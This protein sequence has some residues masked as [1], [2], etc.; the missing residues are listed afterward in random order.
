MLEAYF[1]M[2]KERAA[3]GLPP[4]PLTPREVEE[5]CRALET[6]AKDEGAALRGLLEDRVAPGVDAAA[7]VKAGWLAAVAKGA[8]RAPAVPR[9]DA[10][11]ILGTMLGGY[12]VDPLVDALS[13]KAVAAAAA[14][15]LKRIVLVYGRFDAIAGLAATNPFAKAVLESWAAGEWFL[16]RP[17]FPETLVL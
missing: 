6:A 17:A 3:A 9:Q 12:N 16:G 13:D 2:E 10:V 11:R 7:K 4:L 1:A 15:A 8:V 5:V 14:E